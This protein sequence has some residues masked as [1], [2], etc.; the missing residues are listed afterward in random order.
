[1]LKFAILEVA[2]RL[3]FDR[4]QAE[5][6]SLL[7]KRAT[8]PGDYRRELDSLK[9]MKKQL[10]KRKQRK[11]TEKTSKRL[12][13]TDEDMDDEDIKAIER[14]PWNRKTRK[15]EAARKLRAIARVERE[16]R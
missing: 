9:I 3:S 14:E 11:L 8:A 6:E 12:H 10:M 4:Y 15:K 13:D 16:S 5:I 2:P 7:E 1:M